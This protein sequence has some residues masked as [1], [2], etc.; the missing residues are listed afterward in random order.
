MRALTSV[1]CRSLLELR[2]EAEFYGLVRMMEQIDTYPVSLDGMAMG[3]L[4]NA[5]RMIATNSFQK[6]LAMLDADMGS[7]LRCSMT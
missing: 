3:L 2:A 1:V 4:L 5:A 7:D 6:M